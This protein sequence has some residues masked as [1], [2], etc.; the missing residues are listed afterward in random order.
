MIESEFSDEVNQTYSS[1]ALNTISSV[2]SMAK[3]KIGDYVW[4]GAGAQTGSQ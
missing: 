1:L 3:E 2:F 4:S